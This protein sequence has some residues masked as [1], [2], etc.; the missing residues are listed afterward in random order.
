M[1]YCLIIYLITYQ[2]LFS[3]WYT[4]KTAGLWGTYNNEPS[5]DF[6]TANRTNH[7]GATLSS[8][9]N[10]W[11]IDKSCKTKVDQL[12]PKTKVPQ[13]I[14]I[15]CDEFF[16]S[17]VSQLADCF[18]RVPKEYFYSICLNGTNKRNACMAAVSYI[19]MCSYVHTPLRI[20]DSCVQ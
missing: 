7:R 2:L 3:G 9:V 1:H 17:K 6:F 13:E 4:G 8:F 15:L 18:N 19:N 11:S 20:P 12:K 16:T 5:D 14:Q 10:G